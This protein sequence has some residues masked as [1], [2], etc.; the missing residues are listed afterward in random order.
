MMR[1]SKFLNIIDI[2]PFNIIKGRGGMKKSYN[3]NL[4][5]PKNMQLLFCSWKSKNNTL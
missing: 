4:K 5:G 1:G 3:K 2:L